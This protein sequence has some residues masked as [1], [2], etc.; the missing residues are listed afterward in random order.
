MERE[1]VD[2]KVVSIYS[3]TTTDPDNLENKKAA[4]GGA[5]GTHTQGTQGLNK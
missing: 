3:V 5:Q 4:R 1:N 2:K